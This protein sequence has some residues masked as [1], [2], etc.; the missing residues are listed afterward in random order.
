MGWISDF[1]W[2]LGRSILEGRGPWASIIGH[3]CNHKLFLIIYLKKKSLEIFM[4]VSHFL[5]WRTDQ[6][7]SKNN[8]FRVEK[9]A[10]SSF[11]ISA[12]NYPVTFHRGIEEKLDH[13]QAI[14]VDM[15]FQ[16]S[17]NVEW[18]PWILKFCQDVSVQDIFLFKMFLPTNSWQF[19][20]CRKTDKGWYT[21]LIPNT[22]HFT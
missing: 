5:L 1:I 8:S 17:G 10:S 6:N 21:D 20:F 12:P 9:K 18:T 14:R 16:L 22:P 11:R 15:I 2:I 3:L 19:S 7:V 4:C 13:K